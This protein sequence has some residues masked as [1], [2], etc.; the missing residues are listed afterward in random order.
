MPT[1]P[2][3]KPSDKSKAAAKTALELPKPEDTIEKSKLY[4]D[5]QSTL[6]HYLLD[7]TN[8]PKDH[9]YWRMTEQYRS[10]K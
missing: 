3:D 8:I 7:E 10:M 9:E 1:N 4:W 2:F 6:K 5:I